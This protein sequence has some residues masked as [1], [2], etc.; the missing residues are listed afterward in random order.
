[1]IQSDAAFS[2]VLI[3]GALLAGALMAIFIL[4][5]THFDWIDRAV[6]W[7]MA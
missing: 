6:L 4:Y 5:S 2:A 7:V 3:G 1:M